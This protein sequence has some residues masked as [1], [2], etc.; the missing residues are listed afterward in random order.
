MTDAKIYNAL[1][2]DLPTGPKY[3]VIYTTTPL[4]EAIRE[5]YK[6]ESAFDEA[7]HMDLKRDLR[8]RVP[9]KTNET[10]MRPLFEKYQFLTP[11]KHNRNPLSKNLLIMKRYRYFHGSLNRHDPP[12]D[13]ERGYQRSVQFAGFVC[14]V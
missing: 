1:L 10:D 11:G 9:P 4:K 2:K 3:T 6:Y 14:G 12:C 13:L 5:E 7:V 8:L